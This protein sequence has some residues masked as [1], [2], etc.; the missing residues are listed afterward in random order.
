[1]NVPA[2]DVGDQIPE[3][4]PQSKVLLL[5]YAHTGLFQTQDKQHNRMSRASPKTPKLCCRPASP[6]GTGGEGDGSRSR[7]RPD[8]PVL[9][10]P[11]V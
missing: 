1:M 11:S 8:A 10:S 7:L 2:T 4:V 6:P 9:V 3:N 5:S